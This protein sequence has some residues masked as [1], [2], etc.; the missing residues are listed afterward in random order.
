MHCVYL[1][2]EMKFSIPGCGMSSGMQKRRGG[3]KKRERQFH[4]PGGLTLLWKA[5]SH[6][7]LVPK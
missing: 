1:P 6:P 5:G 7:P 4:K 2:R 3:G